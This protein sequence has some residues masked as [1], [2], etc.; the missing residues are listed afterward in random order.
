M[1]AVL[2]HKLK[3]IRTLMSRMRMQIKKS[4]MKASPKLKLKMTL[5]QILKI[6]LPQ[7]LKMRM[8]MITVLRR[9]PMI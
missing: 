3:L 4:L 6:T 5:S 8:R 9:N 7:I 1:K 2:Q